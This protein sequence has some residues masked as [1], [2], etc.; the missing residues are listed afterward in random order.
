MNDRRLYYLDLASAYLEL[1]PNGI[2]KTVDL[3][4]QFATL[5]SLYSEP[6]RYYHNLDHISRGYQLYR[7]FHNSM[8][9]P[10][11]FAW[12]YHDSIY[13]PGDP[14]NEVRSADIFL[15]DNAVIGFGVKETDKITDLIL[16]T[17]HIGEKNV[18][19][20]I[21]LSS[22]GFKEEIYD[23][24]KALI[25]LEYSDFSDEEWRTGREK[26]LTHMLSS[27]RIFVTPGFS[28]SFEAPARQNMRRELKTL[29]RP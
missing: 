22:L 17:R 9:A 16:S 14:D 29:T 19:T 1:A 26:F 28:S 8:P 6:Q 25:R 3:L 12:M 5:A 23:E 18:I 27:G 2:D 15:K 4:C 11:F 21:D 20:D 13:D 10:E 7:L 24:L